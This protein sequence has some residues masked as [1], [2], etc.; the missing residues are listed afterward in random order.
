MNKRVSKQLLERWQERV[1]QITNKGFSFSE[2][3]EDREARVARAK[4][5]YGFFVASYFPHL[6]SKPC[7]KFQIDAARRI[8]AEERAR[9]LYEWARGHAKSSHMGCLI[10]LWLMARGERTAACRFSAHA[11]FCFHRVSV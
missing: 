11:P 8:A 1:N 7:A 9:A 5:D 2:S 4:A 10:P 3:A 6:A